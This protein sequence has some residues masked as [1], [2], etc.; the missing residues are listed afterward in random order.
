MP[1]YDRL[2]NI[3]DH[4]EQDGYKSDYNRSDHY[5]AGIVDHGCYL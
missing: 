1:D 2:N 4:W 3:A 5:S